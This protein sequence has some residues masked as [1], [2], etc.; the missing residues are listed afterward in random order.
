[1]KFY[2]I[3]GEASGDAHAAVLMR[4]LCALRR[5][6]EFFGAGGPRMNAIA[7]GRLFQWTDQAVVGLWDVLLNYGYFRAQFYRMYREIMTIGPEAV[8]FVDYPG[9]NLRLARYL[10]R[11]GYRGRLVFYIS[12]QVWAWNRARIPKMAGYLDLM[13]C[14][15]PF[16]PAL[17][18]QSGLRAEFVGHPMVNELARQRRDLERDPLLVGLFPGS[19][20]REV[21]RIFPV[22]LATAQILHARRPGLRFAASAA[23]ETLPGRMRRQAT[24]AGFPQMEISLRNPSELMQRA[25][26]GMVASGT[27]TMEASFFQMPFVLIY[28]V[29]WVTYAVARALIRVDYLGMPNILAG[30]PLIPEFIQQDARPPQ[31]ALALEKLAGDEAARRTML[32]GMAEVI[33]SLGEEEAG[34]RAAKALLNHLQPQRGGGVSK[35]NLGAN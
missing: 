6:V 22:M 16:E 12:P 14:I 7:G 27:A 11:H 25:W 28:K 18:Q 15:F 9:F 10:K 31:I 19:R 32:N 4:E 5:D 20:V 26:V 13:L 33:G 35:L 23:N 8:I 30:R 1:M 3:A 2:L 17:Y 29:S 34:P 24:A 21:K